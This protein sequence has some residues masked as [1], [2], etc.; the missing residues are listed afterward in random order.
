VA[1]AISAYLHR[2]RPVPVAD[3]SKLAYAESTVASQGAR[4]R[5]LDTSSAPGSATAASTIVYTY[6]AAGR[7]ATIAIG[8][9]FTTIYVARLTGSDT[10]H[11]AGHRIDAGGVQGP[12][13]GRT[14]ARTVDLA[15]RQPGARLGPGD[16]PLP[17]RFP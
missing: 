7:A 9:D 1:G 11:L 15:G 10:F 8:P 4:V 16:R 5:V 2:R 14:H 12:L 6:P 17:G 13:F 3:G